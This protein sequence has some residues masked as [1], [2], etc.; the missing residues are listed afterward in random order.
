MKRIFMAITM[1]CMLNTKICAMDYYQS[2][3]SRL[4]D[5]GK[6]IENM[7][8][9]PM[10]GKLTNL[11]PFAALAAGL[12]ECPMQTIAVLTALGIYLLSYNGTISE[13]MQHYE[14]SN[15]APWIRKK[16][17]A[18]QQPIIDDGFFVY[19]DEEGDIV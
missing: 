15:R 6:S 17:I 16:P 11:L 8:G 4:S 18:L 14:I 9:L 7:D 12:Q 5:L 13:M 3:S 10:I 2:L 19:D 1:V